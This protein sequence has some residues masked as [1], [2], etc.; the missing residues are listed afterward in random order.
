MTQ[1]IRCWWCDRH[2]V[3]GE[4]KKAKEGLLICPHCDG[5]TGGTIDRLDNRP[6]E[7]LHLYD[8]AKERGQ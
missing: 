8:P 2:F 5:W 6:F 3:E 4:A 1:V 7:K